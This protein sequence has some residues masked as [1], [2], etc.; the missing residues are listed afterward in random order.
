MRPDR[1]RLR[2]FGPYAGEQ[3]IDFRTLKNQN[4]VLICGPVGAGKTALLDGV[5]Y[6]LYGVTSGGERQGFQMRSHFADDSQPTEV[7]L[8]FRL[9]GEFYRVMRRP[10]LEGQPDEAI[11]SKP[12]EGEQTRV[13]AEGW[14]AVD[15]AVVSL[16]GLGAEQFC[17]AAMLPQ[18]QFRR[19]LEA[20]PAEREGVLANLFH[21]LPFQHFQEH[22]KERALEG[23]RELD[24]LR[25][26]RQ[27]A[28]ESQGL[29]SP[30]A[31]EDKL[32]EIRARVQEL[33]SLQASL[34]QG[35]QQAENQARQAEGSQ[36][37]YL[38]LDRAHAVY[39]KLTE[40]EGEMTERRAKLEQL[41]A[42]ADLTGLRANVTRRLADSEAAQRTLEQAQQALSRAE[43]DKQQAEAEV[44]AARRLSSQRQQAERRLLE[45]ESGHE[46]LEEL[47]VAD[48]ELSAA[49][50]ILDSL[51]EALE[52]GRRTGQ[53]LTLALAQK[54]KR[55]GEIDPSGKE[56][57][58]LSLR[59]RE[60]YRLYQQARQA[61]ELERQLARARKAIRDERLHNLE[62][63]VE[64]LKVELAQQRQKRGES[65]VASLAAQLESGKPCPVCGSTKHPRPAE[66][67]GEH[68]EAE[69][70][71][72]LSNQLEQ[73][74]RLLSQARL[75]YS[76]K[77]LVV[78]RLQARFDQVT[79]ELGTYDL[80]RLEEEY[81]R[82]QRQLDSVKETQAEALKLRGDLE[83]LRSKGAL[84]E[85]R[86]QQVEEQRRQ[87]EQRVVQARAVLEE[88]RRKL[89]ELGVSVEELEHT[90]ELVHGQLEEGRRGLEG[91]QKA[92][93]ASAEAVAA[94]RAAMQAAE[95]ALQR[96]LTRQ[97]EA[98]S[99]LK[100]RLEKL[101]LDRVAPFEEPEAGWL[102]RESGA[103]RR[104]D[105]ELAAA[106]DR[107]ERA[108]ATAAE[109]QL[110]DPTGYVE[111]R[112]TSR[113]RLESAISE[114]ARLLD[115][116]DQLEKLEQELAD[117]KDKLGELESRC[118]A[119]DRLAR[120]AA[121]ENN[122]KTSYHRFVLGR[123]L[124]QVLEATEPRLR[125]LSKGRFQLLR[126]ESPLD[127]VALDHFTGRTRSVATL[128][129]GESFLASL[130][131]ALGLSD[132]VHAR[133]QR[134]GLESL[135]VDEGF[136]FLDSEALDLAL[137]AL[138]ELSAE[139]RLVAIVSQLPEMRER[140][141]T[142]IEVTPGPRGSTARF[143]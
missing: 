100:G 118:Q 113:K 95:Q 33:E 53:K 112:L 27:R 41:R 97:Q 24:E 6:A 89:E 38:E 2:A 103:L 123:L 61:D 64:R 141:P 73:A 72:Q 98:Q 65:Q 139:G 107:L 4:F 115:R 90:W 29:D 5:C 25:E 16:M 52:A 55:L 58:L 60:A 82:L 69:R 35:E 7:T 131:L 105:E 18:G 128:S 125:K 43:E 138:Q 75:E 119:L 22:L 68:P 39:R 12:T 86:Q 8:D 78:E 50:S 104:Y 59:T 47:R 74:E 130:A 11:L 63:R 93:R 83:R 134:S 36:E 13:L 34:R 40:R 70:I 1:L 37:R 81:V 117:W 140:V 116:I 96:C 20:E 127:L 3:L 109:M 106:R 71:T 45:L 102:E 62:E 110:E 137:Q 101:G 120:V 42:L 80:G 32:A 46:R 87:A 10:R 92:A 143:V 114:E 124:E 49:Q 56:R 57:E 142:R 26:T 30:E 129:G 85:P 108:R 76:D 111:Q 23:A 122:L 21:T 91:A 84:L 121:G 28:L 136:G 48:R 14:T 94:A 79:I 9:Q 77:K 132:A 126:G 135:W 19:F 17:Q 15:E 44:E 133:E 67:E 51:V 88:R 54:E 99:E 66:F 31:L